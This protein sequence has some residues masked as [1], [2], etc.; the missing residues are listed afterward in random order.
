MILKLKNVTEIDEML[1]EINSTYNKNL[2]DEDIPLDDEKTWKL[3]G[4]GDTLGVFQFASPLGINVL[5]QIKPKNLEELSAANAFIRPGASGL[6]EYLIAKED[7][8]KVIKLDPR[9]DQY[10]KSTY[11]SIV[12]QEQIM[13]MISELMGISFGEADLYRRALEKPNKPKNKKYV[14][15][16]NNEVVKTASLRG[17]DPEVAT[18]VKNLILDNIG[19][20]FNKSHSI[21]YSLISY[22]T[23]WLKANYPLVFYTTMF[24]GNLDNL[25]EFMAEAKKNDITVL[26][27]HVSYSQYNSIIESEDDRS[28]RIG[29]NSVKGIGPK[30][31]ESITNEQPFDSLND[32]INRTNGRSVNKRVV[33]AVIKSGSSKDLGIE[34][35]N[36][37]IDDEFKSK[38]KFKTINNQKYVM[39]NRKQ[40]EFWYEKVNELNS[41][42]SIPKYLVP[43][44]M[45]KGKFFDQYEFVI[46]DEDAIVIPKD[47]LEE[48]DIQFK[49]VKEFKTR[50]WPKG[51]FAKKKKKKKL[52]PL[53]RPFNEFD[54]ELSKIEI[55][56]LE[57]YLDETKQLGF[58]FL[59][60]PLENHMDKI[61]LYDNKNDGEMIT[62]AGIIT[63]LQERK[64]RNNNLYYWVFLQ[65]PR[66]VVR[67]TMWDNQYKKYNKLVKKHKLIAIRGTKGYGGITMDD[68][69]QVSL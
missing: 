67:I 26:P 62:T 25:P 35:E 27:P 58:S 30:A 29:L 8:S 43:T 12:Y 11:G 37:D 1:K 33:E 41:T 54:K 61:D 21:A 68:L 53:R 64:T 32:L 59:E 7:E 40:Q 23:A 2:T 46:E 47:R 24:N 15:K 51:E 31:V 65:T 28:I 66:D 20:G 69:K 57:L 14:E 55:D 3:I 17:F 42:K 52:P 45:I 18:T 39:L 44:T 63:G 13:Y 50:K 34:V 36:G 48:L 4:R 5:K 49:D 16:F 22:Q 56:Y 6:E 19:Y 9:L 38:F 60:H 10:L